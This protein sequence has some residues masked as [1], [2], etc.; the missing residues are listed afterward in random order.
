[1]AAVFALFSGGS[2]VSIESLLKD[3][4]IKRRCV[5]CMHTVQVLLML[6]QV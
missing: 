6:R 4:D 3:I 1:M 5:P 2:R